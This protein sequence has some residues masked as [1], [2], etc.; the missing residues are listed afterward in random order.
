M[1]TALD[2]TVMRNLRDIADGHL[3][4]WVEVH[5]FDPD[6]GQPL[7]TPIVASVRPDRAPSAGTPNPGGEWWWPYVDS[8]WIEIPP[9]AAAR[10]HYQ[11]S[12]AGRAKLAELTAK[13]AQ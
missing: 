11:L 3:S 1:A 10:Q 9:Q 7:H 5:R 2:V 6:T 4:L 12:D 13:V 8:G